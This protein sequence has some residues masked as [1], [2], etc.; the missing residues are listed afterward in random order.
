[1]T[2][3]IKGE[4]DRAVRRA[5]WAIRQMQRAAE[6]IAA[7]ENEPDAPIASDYD[8]HRD[9]HFSEPIFGA[10]F[11]TNGR[12]G[13]SHLVEVRRERDGCYGYWSRCAGMLMRPNDPRP[14]LRDGAIT[15]RNCWRQIWADTRRACE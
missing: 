3:D 2:T 6:T 11:I 4:A 7:A 15:C 10:A 1:M 13:L 5:A 8:P 12:H 14:V 9:T